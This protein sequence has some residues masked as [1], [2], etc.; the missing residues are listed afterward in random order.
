[1]KHLATV[2]LLAL[3]SLSV[4]NAVAGEYLVQQK[5]CDNLAKEAAGI[6]KKHDAGVAK[7]EVLTYLRADNKMDDMGYRATVP[8]LFNIT[9]DL[10]RGSLNTTTATIASEV[11]AMCEEHISTTIAVNN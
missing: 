11:S 2:L 10:Y 3:G 7:A 1:M 6:S 9:D 4:A 8:L 5:D